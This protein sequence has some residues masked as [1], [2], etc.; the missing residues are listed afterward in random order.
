MT[1]VFIDIVKKEVLKCSI[2]D[3]CKVCGQVSLHIRP[4]S[5]PQYEILQHLN[6]SL[7][8]L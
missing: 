2:S 7:N 3:S 4:Q 8:I 6:P 1:I 5:L